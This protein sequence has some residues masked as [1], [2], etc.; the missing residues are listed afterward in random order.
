MKVDVKVSS[1]ARHVANVKLVCVAA[2]LTANAMKLS[3]MQSLSVFSYRQ[4]SHQNTQIRRIQMCFSFARK[5][6]HKNS[7]RCSQ[8]STFCL[9][10]MRFFTKKRSLT[11]PL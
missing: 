11:L 8:A 7:D 6:C 4:R 9:Q 10:R 5:V 1:K 2:P 3:L